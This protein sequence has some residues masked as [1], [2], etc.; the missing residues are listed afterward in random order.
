MA[1]SILQGGREELLNLRS[2][3]EKQDNGRK[4]AEEL[5]KS[6]SALTKE[7]DSKKKEM[8]A[9]IDS[10]MKARKAEIESTYNKEITEL[11]KS[12]KKIQSDKAK[13]KSA[14]VSE[15]MGTETE[16]L[17]GKI[18]SLKLEINSR[19]R[20]YRLP[21]MCKHKLF[22]AVF[23]PRTVLDIVFLI[24]AFI[25]LFLGLPCTLFTLLD[26]KPFGPAFTPAFIYVLDI[27]IFGGLY[28]LINNL[29]KDKHSNEVKG[30]A[31]L[32]NE[33]RDTK[34]KIRMVKRSIQQDTDES[35]YGLESYDVELMEMESK[36]TGLSEDERAALETFSNETKPMLTNEIKRKYEGDIEALTE[37]FND[38]TAEYK[39][40]SETIRNDALV[41]S[42]NF[43]AQIGKSNMTVAVMDRLLSYMDNGKATTIGEALAVDKEAA[44]K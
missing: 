9:E 31:E 16:D 3:I 13:V 29:V 4:R 17:Y 39:Q 1:E 2:M 43:E 30:I 7:I 40:V 22:Y 6:L 5:A 19:V 12:K 28:M 35:G 26:G 27:V 44:G 36:L 34:R 41:L 8:N 23:M 10:T 32:L 18:K 11:N 25:V 14:K 37:K 24:F 15:R 20:E 33:I 21:G 38:Q 42:T